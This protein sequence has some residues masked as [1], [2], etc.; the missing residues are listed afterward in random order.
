MSTCVA[1][2]GSLANIGSRADLQVAL[3]ATRSFRDLHSSP[4]GCHANSTS[5]E[6]FNLAAS[7]SC[8]GCGCK[9]LAPNAAPSIGFPF[10][11][12]S[13]SVRN[14]LLKSAAKDVTLTEAIPHGVKAFADLAESAADIWVRLT[15]GEM[16]G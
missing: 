2:G 7:N 16:Q 1:S 5:A 15:S 4:V 9:Y 11:E 3:R 8:T 10:S 12:A 6:H 14:D 13:A